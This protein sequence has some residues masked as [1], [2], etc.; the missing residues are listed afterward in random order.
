MLPML[1]FNTMEQLGQ[2]LTELIRAGRDIAPLALAGY[3]TFRI[4]EVL[5][6]P[7]LWGTV[8][9]TM[10]RYGLARF[11]DAQKIRRQA[12]FARAK[13][14]WLQQL[15]SAELYIERR[16]KEDSSFTPPSWYGESTSDWP[17]WTTSWRTPTP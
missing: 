12:E 6:W 5:A 14:E 9:W 8:A 13:A 4:L 15:L 3:F 11:F 17:G 1:G 2:T 10:G 16:K 7:A